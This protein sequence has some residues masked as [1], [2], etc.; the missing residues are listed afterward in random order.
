MNHG[1]TR[2]LAVELAGNTWDDEIVPFREALI[3]VEKHWQEIGIQGNCPY[4]FM[5]EELKGHAADAEGWNEVQD[6]FD[7]IEG[8][9]K[10]DGWTHPETFDAA[11]D[12]FSNSGNQV[13]R[14]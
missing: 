13:S 12:F 6:F 1:K 4:H 9:V 8:L 7:S 11:F 2:R 10:R 14:A 5:E 3:N